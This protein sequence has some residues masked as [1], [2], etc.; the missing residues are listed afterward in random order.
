MTLKSW[1]DNG[2]LIKH[3]PTPQEIADLLKVDEWLR[4][5]HAELMGQVPS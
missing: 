3:E 1:L 5:N 2:W 4:K